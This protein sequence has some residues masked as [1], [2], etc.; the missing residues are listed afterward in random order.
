MKSMREIGFSLKLS[1]LLVSVV[2]ATSAAFGVSSYIAAR[3]TA[4]TAASAQRA[5]V[6]SRYSAALEQW[7][8]T[9]KTD[10]V[11]TAQNPA[12]LAAIQAFSQVRQD[13]AFSG[14]GAPRNGPVDQPPNSSAQLNLLKTA[15]D[16]SGY[17]RVYVQ[18]NPFFRALAAARGYSEI[19]LIDAQ[20]SLVSTIVKNRDLLTI[21][22]RSTGRGMGLGKIIQAAMAADNGAVVFAD[23]KPYAPDAGRNAA[24]VAT[25]VF[26]GAN[27]L[28]GA[29]VFQIIPTPMTDSVPDSVPDSVD[30]AQK[31]DGP[32]IGNAA[33]ILVIGADGFS[34]SVPPVPASKGVKID[35]EQVR[36]AFGLQPSEQERVRANSAEAI[37]AFSTVDVFGIKWAVRV[38]QPSS[39]GNSAITRIKLRNIKSSTAIGLALSLVGVMAMLLLTAPLRRVCRSAQHLAQ[40]RLSGPIP[41][42]R[43]VDEIGKIVAALISLRADQ[44]AGDVLRKSIAMTRTAFDNAPSPMLILDADSIIVATNTAMQT[45]LRQ[46]IDAMNAI[47]PG[48]DPEAVIGLSA[49]VFGVNT[50][51]FS[52]V[53]HPFTWNFDLGSKRIMVSASVA[54]SDKAPSALRSIIVFDDITESAKIADIFQQLSG[55]MSVVEYSPDGRAVATNPVFGEVFGYAPDETKGLFAKDLMPNSA[56]AA[57][58][59]TMMWERLSDGQRVVGVFER[60][61]RNGERL[62][63]HASFIPLSNAQGQIYQIVEITTDITAVEDKRLLK[64]AEMDSIGR[65]QSLVHLSVDG[66][67]LNANQN[68]LELVGYELEELQGKQHE[69]LVPNDVAE[70]DAYEDLWRD[71]SHGVFRT[72]V[73]SG[74]TKSGAEIYVHA[75]FI[76]V[77]DRSGTVVKIIKTAVDVTQKELDQREGR[78]DRTKN[79]TQINRVVDALNIGLKALSEGDLTTFVETPFA[80]RYDDLRV[81]F[82][83]AVATLHE[84]MIT[85]NRNSEAIQNGSTEIR[86][87]AQELAQRTEGQA[88]TLAETNS[89]LLNLT[90][91]IEITAGG[92]E[93]AETAVNQARD[94]AQAGGNVVQNAIASMGEIEKSSE[95]ISHIIGVIED[96]AF[97]TN[98]LALNAS[99][100]AARAGEAGR[101]FAVVAAEVR[102]LSQRSSDAAKEIKVLIL[103]STTQVERG[104]TLVDNLRIS[105]TNIVDG[106]SRS[107]E[108]VSDIAAQ[109]KEQA[110]G[111]TALTTSMNHLDQVTRKN[112]AMVDDTFAASQNMHSE[113]EGF[114]KLVARFNLGDQVEEGENIVML[115]DPP[116]FSAQNKG[117]MPVI[118]MIEVAQDWREF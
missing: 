90:R 99:V 63:T 93:Q 14:V 15:T 6:L 110:D 116:A 77:K 11:L 8:D 73:F 72:G 76:P 74:L 37:A 33:N 62:W 41:G 22:D 30:V 95:Q 40:R 13:A 68:F 35:A 58:A 69:I 114:V 1:V 103:K 108:L 46:N 52:P 39:V 38:E 70:S 45:F 107:A 61:S 48:F 50:V 44:E 100:E 28:L 117:P 51:G 81:N 64:F 71:I 97:Q 94:A 24:F 5:R 87:G 109:S 18:Y 79:L 42:G 27:R 34:R 9:V 4:L 96:I 26:G 78:K 23:F 57:A 92:A 91:S 16:A 3:E 12:T 65:A 105:L 111:V 55:Y 60:R 20:G 36:R 43:R 31:F 113:L 89:A 7:V 75:R 101:G 67:I 106:V 82:N 56:E 98:L 115:R 84:T 80:G 88:A 32:L 83:H 10:L 102:A 53:D 112:A 86:Q 104:V 59:L 85:A 19:Y 47:T 2:M 25:P 54:A 66:K 29:I 17:D 21:S 118:D 49:T